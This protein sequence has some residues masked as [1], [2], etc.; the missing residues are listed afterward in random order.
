MHVYNSTSPLQRRVTFGMS[1]EQIKKIAVEGVLLVKKLLPEL[2]DTEIQLEY[3]PESFSDTEVDYALE[4]CEAVMD[5]WEPTTQKSGYFKL[6]C[7]GRIIYPEY[8]CRPDRM[9]CKNLRERDKA[10][11]SLHTIMTGEPAQQLTN[12]AYWQEPIGLKVLCL[13]TVN[14]QATS[15]SLPLH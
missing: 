14:E 9:V 4:V 15:T 7:H 3:S 2:P 11:I 8:S 10:I 5:A 1:K 13:A 12:L 6:T